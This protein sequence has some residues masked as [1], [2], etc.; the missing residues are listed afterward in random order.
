MGFDLGDNCIDICYLDRAVIL[1]I[2]IE[3]MITGEVEP[4]YAF[5]SGNNNPSRPVALRVNFGQLAI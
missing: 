5:R 1:A 3:M 4:G 2:G